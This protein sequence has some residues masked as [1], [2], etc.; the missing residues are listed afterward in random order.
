MEINDYLDLARRR[1]WI[2]VLVGLLAALSAY[3]FSRMQTPIYKATMEV[4]LQ[5]ARADFGLAESTKKLTAS[6]I[7]IVF[8]RKNAAEINKRLKLDYTPDEIY[9]N[10][11]AGEDAAKYGVVIEVRDQNGDTAKDIAYAWAQLFR[12]YRDNENAKQSRND[13]VDAILG[14]PPSTYSKDYPRTSVITVAAGLLGALIGALIVGV[15]EWLRSAHIRNQADVK[16]RLLLPVI[17][18]IPAEA[19]G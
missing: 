13:R 14:D 2:V 9:E 15:L 18:A 7:S 1:A 19:K 12:E 3:V 10:T 6:Y 17:G 4:T 8:S 16:R 5:P 11:K